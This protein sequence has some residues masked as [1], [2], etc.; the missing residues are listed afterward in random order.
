LYPLYSTIL[1][2]FYHVA[3]SHESSRLEELAEQADKE[4]QELLKLEKEAGM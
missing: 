2:R 3:L 1:Q 4:V